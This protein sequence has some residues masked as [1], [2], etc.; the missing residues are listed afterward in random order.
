MTTISPRHQSSTI[1][2]K[3]SKDIRDLRHSIQFL[4][5]KKNKR[6]I[7]IVKSATNDDKVEEQQNYKIKQEK[8]EEDGAQL[9]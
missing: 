1:S 8:M 4:D 9:K 3:N 5:F 6:A 2:P 7:Q